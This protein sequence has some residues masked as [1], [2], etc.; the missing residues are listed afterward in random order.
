MSL[1]LQTKS[2]IERDV[3]YFYHKAIEQGAEVSPIE[4]IGCNL[5]TLKIGN[6]TLTY[7]GSV[8]GTAKL[9]GLEGEIF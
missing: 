9:I 5:Y 7:L 8:D 3:N 1:E 6:A 2:F 4:D